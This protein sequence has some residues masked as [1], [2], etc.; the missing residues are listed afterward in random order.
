LATCRK[1]AKKL[2]LPRDVVRGYTYEDGKVV[3]RLAIPRRLDGDKI[4]VAHIEKVLRAG[5]PRGSN[6]FPK[7]TFIEGNLL[8]APQGKL[9]K[10]KEEYT[11]QRGMLRIQMGGSRFQETAMSNL[12]SVIRKLS[13][14]GYA[15]PEEIYL[16]ASWTIDGSQPFA[17]KRK[18]KRRKAMLVKRK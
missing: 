10:K 14:S 13:R 9:G 3:V 6:F 11:R 12:D 18:A 7:G 15:E 5:R 16:R 4:T 2:G 17:K 1:A 8:M